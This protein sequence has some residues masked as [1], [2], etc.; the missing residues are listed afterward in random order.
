MDRLQPPL[1]TVRLPLER[2]GGLAAD[3][4]ITELDSESPHDVPTRTLLGV[5]L[6]VR[7]STAVAPRPRTPRRR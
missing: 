1:T 6:V 2:M 4:L 3:L 5:D 7:S